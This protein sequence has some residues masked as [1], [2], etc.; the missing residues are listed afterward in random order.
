MPVAY[1]VLLIGC[2]SAV[3]THEGVCVN[4]SESGIACVKELKE[5]KTHQDDLTHRQVSKC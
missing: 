5:M 1:L 3:D 4:R 2:P